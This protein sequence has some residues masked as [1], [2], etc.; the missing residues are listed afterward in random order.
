MGSS[1]A[2]KIFKV[3]KAPNYLN[4]S[5]AS[6]DVSD[7]SIKYFETSKTDDMG[8]LPKVYEIEKLDKG[9]VVDGAVSD[10]KAFVDALKY[11]RNKYK[12]YKF[13]NIALPEEHAFV[14]FVPAKKG[15]TDKSETR[16]FIEFNLSEYIPF[17]PQFAIFDYDV[18]FDENGAKYLAVTV[19]PSEV[20]NDYIKAF[21]GAGFEVIGA[22]LETVAMA[23]ASVTQR[24][25]E[26]GNPYVVLDIGTNKVGVSVFIGLAPVF[27]SAIHFPLKDFFKN[28]YNDLD[29]KNNRDDNQFFEWK[30]REGLIHINEDKLSEFKSGVIK[31]LESVVDYF[32][33]H[34]PDSIKPL[35]LIYLSGGNAATKGLDIFIEKHLQIPVR[36]VNVWANM[37]DLNLYVPE[38]NKMQSFQLA[39]VAGL[40]LKQLEL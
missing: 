2:R 25:R 28:I 4:L 23:R 38:F 39:T 35:N 26:S 34:K 18:F 10:H 33:T 31:E 15:L 27:S 32:N 14:F 40:S 17:D 11:F 16:R 12:K 13:V 22:E 8:V 24:L 21:A 5:A 30:F 19:Y 3:F 29:K 36:F 6:F 7:N 37:F 20:V 9:V 1:M